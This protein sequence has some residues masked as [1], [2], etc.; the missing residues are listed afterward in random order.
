[1]S[2]DDD[3]R[4]EALR[5]QVKERLL[6][7]MEKEP[8]TGE[9]ALTLARETPRGA[10]LVAMQY[11]D[12]LLTRLLTK[13][14]LT[15]N[16]AAKLLN[17]FNAPLGTFSNKIL[18]AYAFGLLPEQEYLNLEQLRKVRNYCAH[19]FGEIHLD[20]DKVR[21]HC[22]NMKV[23]PGYEKDPLP[24]KLSMVIGMLQSW[25]HSVEPEIEKRDKRRLLMLAANPLPV[26]P[27]DDDGEPADFPWPLRSPLR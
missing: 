23:P 8:D 5:E 7:L 20:D 6:K 13:A 18:A 27:P 26:P 14:C 19:H 3:A 15:P 22:E 10:I 4:T 2:T 16:L 24:K 25:L 11:A 12:M 17:D 9:F 21:S 1:M